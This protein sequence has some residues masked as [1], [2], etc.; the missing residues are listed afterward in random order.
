MIIDFTEEELTAIDALDKAYEKLLS[1]VDALILKLRPDDPEPDEEEYERIQAQRPTPPPM[2]EPIEYRT[3]DGRDNVP[4]YSKED[5]DAYHESPEYKAYA[6]ENKRVNDLISSQWD[7]WYNAGSDEWKKARK[8]HEK[9]E[10]EYSEALTDLIKKAEDRQFSALGDDPTAILNDAVSQIERIIINKY[11]YYDRLRTTGSFSAR[12][13]RVLE[14]GL[15]RLDATETRV[16]ITEALRRHREALPE[17]EREELKESIETALKHSPFISETGELFGK[18]AMIE[19]PEETKEKGLTVTRPKNYKIPTTKVNTRLFGNELTTDDRNYFT[20]L[21]LKGKKVL[22]Y[23]N[24]VMPSTA[25]SAPVLDDYDERVYAAVGSCLF[26]GN[27]FIPWV[28]LYNRGMLGLD[29]REKNREV[30]PDIKRDIIESLEKFVGKVTIDNDPTG[31]RSAQDPDFKREIIRES[32]LFY[33]ERTEIVHGQPTEGIAIP[34]GYVPVLYRYAELN[35]NEIITDRI[36]SIYIEGVRYT[37]E[38]M[39]LANATYKRVKE[40]QYHN[41]QKTYNKEIPENKR[42][43]RYDTMA[44]KAGLDFSKMSPTERNRF[45]SRL[46]KYMSSYQASGLFHHYEHKKDGKLFYAVVIYFEEEPPKLPKKK[47]R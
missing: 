42:T 23:A 35:R 16:S 46:D 38:N 30:T 10:K 47:S 9:L 5:L 25:V 15:F 36:E 33:Q 34:S 32:L 12:D 43:I 31:E 19:R 24:F 40:I 29:P 1:D 2:P 6:A 37:R 45:K 22:T 4:I 20:P 8:K 21:A 39:R 27:Q 17:P 13:V 3:V 28:M 14:D 11:N 18:V 7:N 44:S 26:A 41:D